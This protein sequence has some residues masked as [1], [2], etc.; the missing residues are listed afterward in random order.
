ML[1]LDLEGVFQAEAEYERGINR[2]SDAVRSGVDKAVKEGAAEAIQTHRYQDQTGRLTGSIRGYVEVSAPGGATGLIVAL[3]D[4][5]SFVD[6]GT[7]PH[8]IEGNPFLTFKGRDGQWV[9]V[10]S[11]QHPGTKP[12]GFLG[13]ALQKAERVLIREVEIGV[14]DLQ[15]FLDG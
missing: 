5:A 7:R 11:V 13:R 9:T 12:D 1:W 2:F 8:V 6:A 3:T 14:A 15:R 10:R 4:Y